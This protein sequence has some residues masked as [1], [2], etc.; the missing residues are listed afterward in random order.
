M[1]GRFDEAMPT[2]NPPRRWSK[3]VADSDIARDLRSSIPPSDQEIFMQKPSSRTVVHPPALL[4]F[5]SLFLALTVLAVACT[6]DDGGDTPVAWPELVRF[7]E[8]AYRADGFAR[9]GDL[10]TVEEMRALKLSVAD[11][12]AI[13]FSDRAMEKLRSTL[14]RGWGLRCRRPP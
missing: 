9:T 4:R 3:V 10:A 12:S 1:R 2:K 13:S 8:V 5:L 6:R 14:P 7:D 11:K